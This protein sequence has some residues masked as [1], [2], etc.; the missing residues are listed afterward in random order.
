MAIA[1]SSASLRVPLHIPVAVLFSLL[2]LGVGAAI[3]LYHFRETRSL[4][5]AANEQLFRNLADD[6]REALTEGERSVRRTFILLSA[7]ALADATGHAERFQFLPELT[8]L[9]A[10][11]PLIES[12]M[13]GYGDGAFF[14]VRRAGRATGPGDPAVWS[15][16]DAS[17]DD[18]D[19]RAGAARD[20]QFD[21][22]LRFLGST[23]GA[24]A[25]FEPRLTDWYRRA[26]AS[27]ELVVTSP[28]RLHSSGAR[29]MTFARR[30]GSAV[31][32]V[33]VDFGAISAVLAKKSITPSTRMRLVG[34]DHTVLAAPGMGLDTRVASSHAGDTVIGQALRTAEH[35]EGAPRIIADTDGQPW[36]VSMAPMPGFGDEG[37]TLVVATP[38]AEIFAEAYRQRQRSV[39]FAVI[40]VLI[41]FPLAWALSRLLT[42]PLHRLAGVARTVS[43]LHF[44]PQGDTGSVI[45]EVD[46]LASAITMMRTAI[47]RF[48]AMGRDLG[49]ARDLRSLLLEVQAGARDVSGTPWCAV[50]VRG[51]GDDRP[52]WFDSTGQHDH[53]P[54]GFPSASVAELEVHGD[55]PFSLRLDV[56]SGPVWQVLVIPLQT[57]EGQILGSLLLADEFSAA[58]GLTRPEVVGFLAALAGS[59]AVALENQRL[60]E[61]RKDL[62]HGV[63]RLVAE[64]IDAKSP[65]T[66]GHCRRV[67]QIAMRLA[68]AAQDA[69]TGPF[70]SY[71]LDASGWEALQ[72]AS[73]LHD[74]GKLTTP[75]HV[76]DKAAKLETLYNRI[77][78]IRTRF[79]VLKRDAELVYWRGLAEG[80]DEERLRMQRDAAWQTLDEEFAFVARCNRGGEGM[81]VA[82]VDRL[83]RIAGRRWRRTLDD[84]LGLSNAE[85]ARRNGAPELPLPVDEPLLADRPDHVIARDDSARFLPG[86]PWGFAMH[87]PAAL[88]NRGELHNL[89]VERGTLT[90][91]ERFKINEHIV[92]TIIM[93]SRLQFP[94]DLIEVPEMAGGHH[95]TMDGRGYPRGLRREDMSVT[96]RVLA[97]A[98]VFEALTATDRPYKTANSTAEALAIMK[99]MAARQAIDP[100]LLELF[101]SAEVWRETGEHCGSV[102]GAHA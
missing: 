40:A 9:L 73:W 74:C 69:E 90:V 86:N 98:D 18:G 53:D 11:D 20:Y 35:A 13:V 38:D 78:E 5:A 82:A 85:L 14:L 95:E 61:G 42:T 27:N 21:S 77:H 65:H 45:L 28:Y 79:E 99:Q 76:I 4:L 16:L 32:G 1:A 15:V 12:V 87:A 83:E 56:P 33:N 88:Y 55:G 101:I 97:I 24:D 34:R 96:A 63:I 19:V 81:T 25:G 44:Q 71:R 10:T 59:A 70:A 31:F 92:E 8:D 46:Q 51:R 102:P 26:A 22:G 30:N 94:P 43:S 54:A 48:L 80:G 47:A 52:I 84:S 60:L 93:L 89:R 57:G 66:G 2:I 36:H 7:S 72:I 41:S 100:D 49:M 75:E 58:C 3:S 62:L 37:W 50:R 6:A 67:P 64:A 39:M 29:G 68:R 23:I 17:P 91:E